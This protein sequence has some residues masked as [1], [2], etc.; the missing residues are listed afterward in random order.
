MKPKG[1]REFVLV[2]DVGYGPF[3]WQNAVMYEESAYKAYDRVKTRYTAVALC[4]LSPVL[5]TMK[6]IQAAMEAQ[7]G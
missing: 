1:K 3:I 2:L 6:P 5:I 7:D 4:K